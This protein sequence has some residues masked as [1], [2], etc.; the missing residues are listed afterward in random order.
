MVAAAIA[1]GVIIF[2]VTQGGGSSH[3]KTTPAQVRA[4]PVAAT[5]PQLRALA[6]AKPFPLYW[7]GPKPRYTYEL[8]QT[9]DGKVYV[10]YLPPG[11]KVGVNLPNYITVATYPVTN[12][13]T[14]VTQASHLPG[15][16]VRRLPAAGLAVASPRLPKSV[17][18]SYPRAKYLVEVYDPVPKQARTL[19][20]SG[21]V[22]PIR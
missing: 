22:R 6:A 8:T 21:Q 4:I 3:S 17:Y 18:L 1:A 2:L 15:E 5:I 12:G 13:F 16:F 19:V 10:R 7:V 9:G 20:L 14:T 11:V